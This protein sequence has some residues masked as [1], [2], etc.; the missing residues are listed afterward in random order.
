MLPLARLFALSL[1]II[2]SIVLLSSCATLTKEECM[3]GNWQTIGYNDGVAGY[4]SD[5]LASHTKACAKASVAPDYQAWERGRQQG[6]KQYCTV[7][8]AYNIGKRGRTLNSVCPAAMANTLQKVNQQGKE[9]YTL[10]SKLEDDRRLLEKYQSEYSK[11]RNGE[12]LDFK[13]EK[14]ARA[15]L[16]YLPAEFQ[17]IKRRVNNNESRL[18]LLNQM[19]KY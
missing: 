1:P 19:P 9:Y 8:N 14:E 5:R 16:V 7:S 15:R 2:G 6:L 4:Y 10:S 17:R 13:D 3:V 12:M 11:L 18:D